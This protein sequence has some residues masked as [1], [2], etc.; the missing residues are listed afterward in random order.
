MAEAILFD[1]DGVL[2]DACELHRRALNFALT[3]VSGYEIES[4]DFHLFEG[5]PTKVKLKMLAGMGHIREEDI[6]EIC[7]VKQEM[8]IRC[9]NSMFH[10]DQIKTNL[11]SRLKHAEV[12]I[13]VVSNA[14]R[15]TVEHLLRLI[16]VS[17]YV[18]LIISNEDVEHPKPDPEG[19]LKAMKI[20]GVNPNETII[21]EDSE[22]GIKA[23]K[24][25]GAKVVAVSAVNQVNWGAFRCRIG[26]RS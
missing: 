19:Y 17:Q 11:F 9:A 18:D 8:T 25:S 13:A 15:E 12:K 1:L 4:Q 2:V 6:P 20:L 5:R 24:A 14:V 23:A 26:R 10:R 22:V 3:A 21:V 7:R 16:G